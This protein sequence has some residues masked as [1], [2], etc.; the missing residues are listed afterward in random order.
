MFDPLSSMMNLFHVL[1][2]GFILRLSLFIFYL[3][4]LEVSLFNV[5][6]IC[7]FNCIAFAL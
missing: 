5:Q 2:F 4:A 1:Y 7:Y 3:K 6:F